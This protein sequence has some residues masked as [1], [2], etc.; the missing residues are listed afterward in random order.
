MFKERKRNAS[1]A[2]RNWAGPFR[3]IFRRSSVASPSKKIGCSAELSQRTIFED[4]IYDDEG[5]KDFQFLHI[6]AITE[7][8]GDI[9]LLYTLSQKKC[10][11]LEV[12][13]LLEK[14]V[15]Q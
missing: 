2:G 9:Q 13:F 1:K 5:R 10:N 14:S 8:P 15:Y 12:A 3:K 6:S 7:H 4:N 11:I